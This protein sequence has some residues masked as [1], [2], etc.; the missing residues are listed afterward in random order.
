MGFLD[1]MK[2]LL[3]GGGS[4]GAYSHWVYV[5]CGR[6]GEAIKTRI[7]LR[8][9]LSQR[10]EGGY[11]VSK[12]LVGSERCFERVEVQ[13]IFD[14]KHRVIGQEITGGDFITAEEYEP[15]SDTG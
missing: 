13:L 9:D 2:S 3:A 11:V 10:D 1:G 14:E 8:N 7:D 15:S 6:C 4:E 5:R 12:T